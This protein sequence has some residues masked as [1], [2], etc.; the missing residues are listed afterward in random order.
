[1]AIVEERGREVSGI[2]KIEKTIEKIAGKDCACGRNHTVPV[3][4]IIAEKGAVAKLPALI[5]EYNAKKVFIL[6]DVNTYEVA[7]KTVCAMLDKAGIGYSRY[8]FLDKALEPDE[9]AVGSAVMHF[10]NAC[11]LVIA[12]GSGVI[13]DIGK[14]L[15]ATAKLPYFIVGTAPS[16]DGY[17]S[18]TS[19]M[20]M[21][22][23][24][25]SLPS[26]CAEVIIGDLDILKN[27]P[28]RMLQAGLGDMLAKYISIAEWRIAREITGEYY[29]EKIAELIRSALKR[30]VENA[31]GLL[32][33]EDEA[34]KAV[35]EG[36][37]LGGIAMALAGVSRPAS[38][39]EH[40]FSHI[41]D[42][43]GLEFGSKVDLHGIQ[44]AVATRIAAG[45]YE[46]VLC[47]TPDKEKALAYAKNFDYGKWSETLK[48]FL[49]KGAETMIALEEKEQK[50]SVEKHAKRL[51]II[52][53]KWDTICQIVR[54][55][56]PYQKEIERILEVIGAP[57]TAQEIGIDCD[58]SLTLKATK[59]IRDKYVLSRL[60]WD[61]GI[62]EEIF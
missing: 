30:C 26:K 53:N 55:E 16:M 24:K 8:V 40:Y 17:A 9:K 57:K 58:L 49:G 1:M 12:V 51:E 5:A 47:L 22:G 56:I 25:V 15:A 42:M 52:I 46:K 45:L 20:S 7:G 59:D 60:L 4:Q 41:W 37:V 18:A 31:E 23:L 29:C 14:I 48:S 61:L 50:Y 27:A 21:D 62:I 19:S 2:M 28:M 34:V 33:R 35:F 3:P 54:E 13:N 43:R 44:C 36:L 11:D 6:A 38:G 10:D 39:V 32:R